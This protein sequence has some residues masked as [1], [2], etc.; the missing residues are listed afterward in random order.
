MHDKCLQLIQTN[1]T[2]IQSNNLM[3]TTMQKG[4]RNWTLRPCGTLQPPRC[5]HNDK[6]MHMLAEAVKEQNKI[7]WNNFMKGR[8]SKKWGAAQQVHCSEKQK[9]M[10]TDKNHN[11]GKLFQM[12]LMMELFRMFET[13]WEARNKDFHENT[14]GQNDKSLK[15]QRVQK[16]VHSLCKESHHLATA[17]KKLF[18]KNMNNVLSK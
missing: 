6:L 2:Q 17:D 18:P 1:L 14:L 15:E 9:H 5:C 3:K 4:I 13:L 7:G 10:Q 8:I 12:R 16:R 11:T